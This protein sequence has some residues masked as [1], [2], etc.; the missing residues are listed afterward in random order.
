L[1]PKQ[2]AVEKEIEV[3]VA[4]SEVD[5]DKPIEQVEEVKSEIVEVDKEEPKPEEA[6]AEV[7]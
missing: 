5:Q 3:P 4:K 7:P 1:P 6:V 2:V